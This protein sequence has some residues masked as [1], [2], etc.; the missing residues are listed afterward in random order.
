[1][2]LFRGAEMKCTRK[3]VWPLAVLA[4]ACLAVV[5][6][7]ARAIVTATDQDDIGQLAINNLINAG[8]FYQFGFFGQSA[9]VANI[10]G[11]EIW[12]GHETTLQVNTYIADPSI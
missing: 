11:G 9:I 7:P 1:M 10:E 6:R 3:Q 2:G 4:A 8:S 12:N 5:P